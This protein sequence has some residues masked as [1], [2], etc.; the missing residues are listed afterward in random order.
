MDK[1]KKYR[2]KNPDKVKEIKRKNYEKYK[3]RNKIKRKEYIDKNWPRSQF[4]LTKR[5]AEVNAKVRKIPFNLTTKDLHE[6][7]D[8]Q[9]GV[10]ALSGL[11]FIRGNGTGPS[12]FTIGLDRIVPALG[13]VKG[14]VRFILHGLNALK[15]NGTDED[16]FK[17]IR[18]VSERLK[19]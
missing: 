6:V 9:N 16:V 15:S 17:I 19:L 8:I 2:L 10:C 3:D 5:N 14:N 7:Y 1:Y 11:S 4:G 18:A 13:Y 12:I